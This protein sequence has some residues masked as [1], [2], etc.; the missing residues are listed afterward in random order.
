MTEERKAY[1]KAYYQANKAKLNK[2]NKDYRDNNKD[3]IKAY[4]KAYREINQDKLKEYQQG[5]TEY[6]K[7]Y[8]ANR[9][10]SDKLFKLKHNIRSLIRISFKSTKRSKTELILGCTFEEFK[11]HI[12]SQFEDWMNWDNYGNPKDG[13]FEPNKT[14]DIDHIIPASSGLTET[15]ILRLNHHTNLRPLCSYVNRWVKRNS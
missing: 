7:N 14:W 5:R 3:K 13:V 9:S 1:L 8:Q 12:E 2:G 11:L 4:Q 15:E 10:K 6:F